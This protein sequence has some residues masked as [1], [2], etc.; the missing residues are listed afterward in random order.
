[1]SIVDIVCSFGDGQQQGDLLYGAAA[2]LAKN[3]EGEAFIA[4]L[5]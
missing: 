1:M 4:L 2:V 5:F 3:P